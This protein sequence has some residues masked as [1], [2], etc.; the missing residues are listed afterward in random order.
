VITQGITHLPVAAANPATC[1]PGAT[2]INTIAAAPKIC[3]CIALNT[4]RCAPLS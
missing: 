3:A 2:Y 1:S 4:W